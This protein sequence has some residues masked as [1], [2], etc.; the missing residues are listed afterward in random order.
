MYPFRISQFF[1]SYLS[2]LC[3]HV[4]IPQ[5]RSSLSSWA[6]IFSNI[7]SP[8]LTH[9]IQPSSYRGLEG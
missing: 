3:M 4:N 1:L 5:L 6:K 7:F 9:F 8:R 2:C